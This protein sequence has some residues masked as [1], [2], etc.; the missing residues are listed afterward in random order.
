MEHGVCFAGFLLFSPDVVF[1]KKKTTSRFSS[2]VYPLLCV[3]FPRIP[4]SPAPWSIGERI[5]RNRRE[6]GGEKKE[7]AQK[8]KVKERR[9]QVPLNGTYKLLG[10][11]GPGHRMGW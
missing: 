2:S 9:Y 5:G 1:S 3:H 10:R 4:V 8:W 11:V 6:K 7:E